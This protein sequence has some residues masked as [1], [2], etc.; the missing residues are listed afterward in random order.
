MSRVVWALIV[1]VVAIEGGILVAVGYGAWNQLAPEQQS[2]IAGLSTTLSGPALLAAVVVGALPV[3]AIVLLARWYVMPL[4]PL[5]EQ[6]RLIAVSNARHRPPATGGPEVREVAGA[7]TLLADTFVSV[8]DDVEARIRET[9]SA[10]EEERNTLAALMS[11]LT[12]GVLVCNPEGRILL[13]N[14]LAQAMLQ[15]GEGEW[16]GLGRSVYTVLEEDVIQHALSH[17]QHRL[18][19]S[20]SSLLVPFVASRPGGQLLSVHLVP[21]L[22]EGHSLRGYILTIDDITQRSGSEQRRGT[23]LQ[24]LVQGQRSSVA[25]IRAAIEIVLSN[26]DLVATTREQFL[27]V[28]NDESTRI[29]DQLDQLESEYAGDLKVHWPM[30]EMLG[31]DLLAAMARRV[32]DA[33]NIN[34][35]VSVPLQPF[36]LRVDSYSITQ[37]IVFLVE[38]VAPICR[39]TN[40]G[41]H[42]EAKRQLAA[43]VLDWDGASLDMEALKSWWDRTVVSGTSGP[44]LSLFDVVERHG[45]ATWARPGGSGRRPSLHLVLPVSEAAGTRAKA[46]QADDRAGPD[47][48][49]RLFSQPTGASALENMPL[50][51]LHYTV[52]DTETTGLDP[53]AGDEIIAI[54]AVRI[55]NGRILKRET[56]DSYVNPRRPVSAAS[57]AIHGIS[58]AM[59]RTMPVIGEVL[60]NLARF[61]EDSVIV[62]HNI[63][64][65]MRFFAMKEEA[66]GVVFKNPVL[67]TLLLEHIAHPNTVD[68][69]LEAIAARLG[70][71]VTGRHTALG[72]ALATAEIFLALLPLLAEKGITTLGQAR[73]ACATHHLAKMTE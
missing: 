24:A 1:A 45:G 65:D 2:V 9:N 31:S 13:Y 43:V 68:K 11:K 28:I 23:L 64:F 38:R 44:S 3:A 22:A 10:L 41:L 14:Q 54:G 26:P 7:V 71:T 49:F 21:I 72:D 5:A 59:L 33:L 29:G 35:E 52:I 42:L 32:R 8:R 25:S 57:Q 6:I 66:T 56:F 12:Q 58:P 47:F 46:E 18:S 16:I 50:S 67:D 15:S 48:D 34:V 37:V 61:V 40:F 73:H 4:R 51:K 17:L 20:E 63:A 19:E 30:D 70:T 27:T 39:A 62:G 69:G 55:V 53:T 36:W 60:P